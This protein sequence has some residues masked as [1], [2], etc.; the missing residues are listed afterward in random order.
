MLF[1]TATGNTQHSVPNK[2]NLKERDH[3]KNWNMMGEWY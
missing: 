2:G 3:F 1:A